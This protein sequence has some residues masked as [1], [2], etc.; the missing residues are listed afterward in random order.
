MI[1]IVTFKKADNELIAELKG[2]LEG[3]F[4]NEGFLK[5]VLSLPLPAAA[6]NEKR[7]QY[8]GSAILRG[9][10]NNSGLKGYDKVLGIVDEDIYAGNLNFVFGQAEAIGGRACLVS[11][12]RLY[13]SFYNLPENPTLFLMRL[14]KEVAHEIGHLLGLAHCH[15]KTCAMTYSENISGV[16]FKRGQFCSVCKEKM[17]ERY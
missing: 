15:N 4:Q 16:D 3:V 14:L 13:Q 10:L 11:T 8:D 7:K 9:M 6:F 5:S 12:R 1:A 17:K 2:R